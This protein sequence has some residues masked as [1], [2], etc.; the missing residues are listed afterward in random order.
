MGNHGTR[1]KVSSV[2]SITFLDLHLKSNLHWEDEIKAIVR[3]CE[4]PMR[5]VNCVKH[6]WWGATPVI[7]MRLYKAL[8]R[9]RLEFIP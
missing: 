9:S 5:F 7:L 3:K 6:T 2:K 1:G 4:N 8:I